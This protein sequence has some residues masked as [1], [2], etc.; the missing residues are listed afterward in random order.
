MSINWT[1]CID[2]AIDLQ[3][4]PF[5]SSHL[6]WNFSSELSIPVTA[7]YLFTPD[8]PIHLCVFIHIYQFP[9]SYNCVLILQFLKHIYNICFDV[10]FF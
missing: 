6:L 4:L 3:T 8:I 10:L 1:I 9:E 5:T 2:L 7:L